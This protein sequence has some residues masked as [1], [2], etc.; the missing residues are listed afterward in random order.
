[1]LNFLNGVIGD[2]AQLYWDAIQKEKYDD[3]DYFLNSMSEDDVQEMCSDCGIT[4][5][6]S[7]KK[8]LNGWRLHQNKSRD[9]ELQPAKSTSTTSKEIPKSVKLLLVPEPINEKQFFCNNVVMKLFEDCYGLVRELTFVKYAADQRE[10]RYTLHLRKNTL[11]QMASLFEESKDGMWQNARKFSSDG[12]ITHKT[13][14]PAQQTVTYL[15]EKIGRCV[16]Y[17]DELQTR[18]RNI[19]SS[20]KEILPHRV[21]ELDHLNALI[22]DVNV[23]HEFLE[24]KKVLIDGKLKRVSLATRALGTVSEATRKRKREKESENRN[25]KEKVQRDLKSAVNTLKLLAYGNLEN[26]EKLSNGKFDFLITADEIITDNFPLLRQKTNLNGLRLLYDKDVFGEQS[27][28]SEIIL[29]CVNSLQQIRDNPK[30]KVKEKKQNKKPSSKSSSKWIPTVQIDDENN[31][32]D[33]NNDDY[34]NDNSNDDEPREFRERECLTSDDDRVLVN[35]D[36]D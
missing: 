35:G 4:P 11:T 27:D 14:M 28:L 17:V 29:K 22:S 8:I 21:N 5:K 34:N 2:D 16:S 1:M 7:L 6:N 32:D 18:K 15:E 26:V 31:D 25:L 10:E 23:V 3:L 24:R 36:S 9:R 20:Q 33:Y 13:V 30:K 19:Y 12:V